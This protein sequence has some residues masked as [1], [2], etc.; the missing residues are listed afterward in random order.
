MRRKDSGYGNNCALSPR[1]ICLQHSE[2]YRIVCI[3][4]E[5]VHG[6]IFLFLSEKDNFMRI[7]F[8]WSMSGRGKCDNAL[9]WFLFRNFKCGVHQLPLTCCCN[10]SASMS[11]KARMD[12]IRLRLVYVHERVYLKLFNRERC[13]A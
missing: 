10:V 11:D 3:R 1:A 2:M 7:V 12:I 8:W 9:A 4:E 6:R 5:W 13:S